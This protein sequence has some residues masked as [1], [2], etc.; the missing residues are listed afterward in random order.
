LYERLWRKEML[1]DLAEDAGESNIY[2]DDV[3]IL[4]CIVGFNSIFNLLR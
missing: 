3:L 1:E 2:A 4:G